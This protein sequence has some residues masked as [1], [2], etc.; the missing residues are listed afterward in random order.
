MKRKNKKKRKPIKEASYVCDACGEDIVIPID[1][2]AGHSQEYVEDCPVCCRPNI[3]RVEI[4][5][6][7]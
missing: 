3:V 4:D 5:E 7:G 1:V 6:D 2:S